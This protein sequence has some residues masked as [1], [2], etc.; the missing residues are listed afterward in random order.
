MKS[1]YGISRNVS[2]E[3]NNVVEGEGDVPDWM[4]SKMNPRC[5]IS[6]QNDKAK[7]II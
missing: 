4:N 7:F 6:K 3:I 2:T 5:P 1:S